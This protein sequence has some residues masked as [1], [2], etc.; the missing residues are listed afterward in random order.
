MT[1]SLIEFLKQPQ[2]PDQRLRDTVSA[3][4]LNLWLKCPLAFKRRYIDGVPSMMNPNFF[5]G[6]VVHD[7]LDG[8]YR[9]AMVG[10]YAIADDIPQFVDDSWARAMNSEPCA[11]S[12]EQEEK[13]KAQAAALVIAY[14]DN[15]DVSNECPLAVEQRYEVPLIDHLTGEDFGIT[16]VGI[17]DLLLDG[18]GGPSIVDFKTSSTASSNCELSHE[19][20]L[21]G[22]SYLIREVFGRKESEL[23]IRQLVKTKSP[24]ILTFSYPPR[25]D[26]HFERFFGIIR[27]YL[28]VIDKG[29]YNYRPG[30]GCQM[31]EHSGSCVSLTPSSYNKEL[32]QCPPTQLCATGN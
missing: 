29:I 27:E 4:K 11:F 18:D 28:A 32:K 15:T 16:L 1:L 30:F 2:S 5:F 3:S 12:V 8:V 22:Y 23:Q 24:K 6:R 10:A 13:L 20:Q 14:L 9:C 31:C 21:T 17:V 7:V 19:I 25:T 26:G